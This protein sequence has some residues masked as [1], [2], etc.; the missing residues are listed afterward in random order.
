MFDTKKLEVLQQA[1]V[2]SLGQLITLNI[3]T[4]VGPIESLKDG[5]TFDESKVKAIATK[6]DLLQGDITT[7]CDQE[8]VT[9]NYQSLRE[10]HAEREKE[11]REIISNNIRTL[12]ELL[13]WVSDLLK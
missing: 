5:L 9:G 6:I 3:V 10:F 2:D 1:I 4:A 11:G 12:Q 8:F 7:V 13:K